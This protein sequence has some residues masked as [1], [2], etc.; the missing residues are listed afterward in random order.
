MG[1][2]QVAGAQVH[3]L[4]LDFDT[5]IAMNPGLVYLY[6]GSYGSA[7]PQRNRAAFN[8]TPNAL[9]GSGIAQIERHSTTFSSIQRETDQIKMTRLTI[10]VRANVVCQ[11]VLADVESFIQFRQV[12]LDL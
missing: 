11:K 10:N 5:V 8:S 6:A 3:R 9:A 12:V 7:G 4:G 1:A 2:Q